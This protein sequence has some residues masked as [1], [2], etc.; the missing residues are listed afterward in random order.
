MNKITPGIDLASQAWLAGVPSPRTL[1][2][3]AVRQSR[4][5]GPSKAIW[6]RFG[7]QTGIS[8]KEFTAYYKGKQKACAI[9][10]GRCWKLPKPVQLAK[11]KQ[12]TAGFRPPQSYHYK[13]PDAF[14]R[15]VGFRRPKQLAA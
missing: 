1:A 8:K 4:I 15:S 6:R 12:D 13:C 2:H 9:V 10:I 14:S 7:H 11:L 3:K 5:S